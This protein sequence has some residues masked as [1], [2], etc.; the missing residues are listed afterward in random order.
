MSISRCVNLDWLELYCLE[1]DIGYPHDANFFRRAG[2]HVEEREYGTPMYNEMFTLYDH[3]EEPLIEIR[4]NPKSAET[5]QING[6]F[7]PR[8]CHV[9]LSNRTCY[10]ANPV[11]LLQQF[12]EQYGMHYQRISRVDICYDFTTFDYG[13]NPADFMRRYMKNRYTKINQA[14]ISAHGADAWGGRTWNSVAWGSKKSM[15][16]TKFYNKKLELSEARDKPYI[17]QAWRAAG[18]VDDE[19]LLT[20]DGNP[21]DIWRVEFSVKS[22]TRNWFIM[23]NEEG[24]KKRIQSV[25]NTLDVYDTKEKL[26]QMFLSL[27]DHYF[28]FKKFEEGKRK[29]LCE[30]KK[31]FN[32]DGISQY[33]KLENVASTHQP[34]TAWHQL[35]KKLLAY[36][37]EVYKPEVYKA[38]SLLLEDIEFKQR[39]NDLT[40]P[41]NATEVTAIRLLMAKRMKSQDNPLS[42][43]KETIEAMLQVENGIFGE[44]VRNGKKAQQ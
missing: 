17:R 37:E 34:N 26:W 12:I 42:V 16:G 22:G 15:V 36:R 25:R 31:L 10:F 30:D 14:N 38:V 27:A 8:S 9:R 6:L 18:L 43:D 24:R 23:E 3:F 21:V 4:R 1:D 2:F 20:K 41:W 19:Y 40:L 29:D 28:H 32:P 7:D 13:D 5:R 33:Y 11:Q 39:T 35:Y 44:S